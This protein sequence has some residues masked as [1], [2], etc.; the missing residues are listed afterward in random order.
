[1][2]RRMKHTT[3]A[4][5][6]LGFMIYNNN[7]RQLGLILNLIGTSLSNFC[8]YAECTDLA[9]HLD[10]LQNSLKRLRKKKV[11]KKRNIQRFTMPSIGWAEPRVMIGKRVKILKIHILHALIPSIRNPRVAV[12]LRFSLH[13]MYRG[14]V[15][16]FCCLSSSV[17][18]FE[19]T[20]IIFSYKS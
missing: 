16:A 7:R 12:E 2:Q 19:S 8:V 3:N 1:M 5:H 13:C 10:K 6:T 4:V 14:L 18:S 15:I 20:E 9:R 17:G 11:L